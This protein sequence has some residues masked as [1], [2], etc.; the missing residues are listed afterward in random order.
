MNVSVGAILVA[1]FLRRAVFEGDPLWLWQVLLLVTAAVSVVVLYRI[2]A[3]GGRWARQLRSRLLLGIPWGT[4]TILLFLLGVFLFVQG[5]YSGDIFDPRQPVTYAF[6]SWSYDYP[7]GVLTAAFSH[8][9]FGHFFGNVVA[10]AVFGSITEYAYGHFPLE[11]GA[12]PHRS[13]GRSPYVRPLVFVGVVLFI[14][15]VTAAFSPGPI[16]GFSGVVYAL[17]GFAIVYRPLSALAGVLLVD[18]VRLLY[19]AFTSPIQTYSPSVQSIGVWFAD[20]AVLGHLLGFVVGVGLAFALLWSR[21]EHPVPGRIWIAA[22]VFGL[23]QNLW[24]VYLPLDNSRYLLLRSVGVAFVFLVAAVVLVGVTRPSRPAIPWPS[25]VPSTVRDSLPSRGEVATGIVIVSLLSLSMAGAA[26][27]LRSVDSIALPNDPVEIRDYQ[28]GYSENVSNEIY[29]LD[30]PGLS[31]GE[32]VQSSGV[33][34][35]SEQRHVW[36][37]ATSTSRLASNGVSR[38]VVGGVGWR[39]TV[40]VTR[41]GWSVVGGAETYRVRLYPP[42]DEPRLAFA[43]APATAE[44][45]IDN[46]SIT[47]RSSGTDFEIAVSRDNETIG[48]GTMPTDGAN[49]TVGAIRFE[50]HGRNLYAAADGT[51]LRI[52]NKKIPPTRR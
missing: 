25:R 45:V 3:P 48:V 43:S 9:S 40:W 22:V 5:A 32:T 18:V 14:S 20:I 30:V 35:Y 7:L 46:R 28:V 38:V 41:T 47:L 11:R 16:I 1:G 24:L 49:T 13:P 12:Q 6:T 37:V 29:S 50:R 52:A 34:V 4:L 2:A 39:E 19:N 51:R 15:L 42:D 36:Q 33:I 44:A 27:N 21:D 10:L 23:V 26:T 17:A 8:G 31:Q